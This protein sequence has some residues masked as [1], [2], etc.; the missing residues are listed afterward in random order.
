MA[1]MAMVQPTGITTA[2]PP[3]HSKSPIPFWLKVL[4]LKPC[5]MSYV[6]RALEQKNSAFVARRRKSSQR[7]TG[8]APAGPGQASAGAE[9]RGGLRFYRSSGP[10]GAPVAPAPASWRRLKT[11][12]GC[13]PDHAIL[14]GL[15]PPPR[16]SRPLDAA[17]VAPR[18]APTPPHAGRAAHGRQA[19]RQCR[20]PTALRPPKTP[21]HACP[22]GCP[23]SAAGLGGAGG[24]LP[25]DPP[26][27]C[28]FGRWRRHCAA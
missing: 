23:Q 22:L 13:P 20:L 27:S 16:A 14:R 18:P 9:R 2:E 25:P 12:H 4:Y 11:R 1:S 15:R 7:A 5:A 17:R 21:R 3:P 19:C 26:P 10:T 24:S 8:L 28:P 6:R